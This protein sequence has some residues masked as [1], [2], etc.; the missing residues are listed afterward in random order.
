MRDLFL[1][2]QAFPYKIIF[3]TGVDGSGKTFLA[4]KLLT[5][6][7]AQQIPAIHVWSR[8]NNYLSK[9]L[10]AFTR[11]IGLNYYEAHGGTRIGYHDFESSRVISGLFVICQLV[12]V[13]I[14]SIIKFWMP[15][16]LRKG[17]IVA[18]RGPHDTLID[19]TLDTGFHNLPRKSIGRLFLKSIPFQ[20]KVFLVVR[21][22]DRIEA[23]RPDVRLDKKFER[24]TGLFFEFADELGFL[25]V[26]NDGTP[27]QALGAIVEDLQVERKKT[28]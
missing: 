5:A 19:V 1:E 17:V 11:L 15:V 4:S 16:I 7:N 20:K 21:D 25:R 3:L 2:K 26:S 22:R 14:A 6:L 8:F 27:E 28:P 10:L 23:C 12:D 24:R 13:W 18:D 9:P